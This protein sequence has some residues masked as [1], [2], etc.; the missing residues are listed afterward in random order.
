MEAPG[1]L[2]QNNNPGVSGHGTRA[3]D[4]KGGKR[5]F[6]VGP[7]RAPSS[8][9]LGQGALKA[10]GSSPGASGW[11]LR[12]Q[13]PPGSAGPELGLSPLPLLPPRRGSPPPTLPPISHLSGCKTRCGPGG[14]SPSPAGKGGRCV[15]SHSA[16]PLCGPGTAGLGGRG[17]GRGAPTPGT[18]WAGGR[19]PRVSPSIPGARP[20]PSRT[21]LVGVAS[22][23]FTVKALAGR[24]F[25]G[26]FMY[27]R[28]SVQ[29]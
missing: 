6:H 14:E 11:A 27:V 8:T 28:L 4:P 26:L 2:Q 10:A 25:P 29:I 20:A 7:E 1:T 3:W 19:R 16:L 21:V 17:G 13:H 18:A 15:S 22:W 23:V 9:A 12:R 24:S 5:D